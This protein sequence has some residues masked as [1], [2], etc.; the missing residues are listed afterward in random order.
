MVIRRQSS[1]DKI[2]FEISGQ[3]SLFGRD[4]ISFKTVNLPKVQRYDNLCNKFRLKKIIKINFL[5][6]PIVVI[7]NK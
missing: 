4:N 3:L 1:L 2:N 5:P 6:I 7:K